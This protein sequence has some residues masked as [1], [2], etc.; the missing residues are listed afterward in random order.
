MSQ[1]GWLRCFV[2]ASHFEQLDTGLQTRINHQKQLCKN[3]LILSKSHFSPSLFIPIW[4][5]FFSRHAWH[6]FLCA[7]KHFSS[8]HPLSKVNKMQ[9]VGISSALKCLRQLV[10]L[11]LYSVF[12]IFC[13]FL[14]ICAKL[15]TLSI[16]HWPLPAWHLQQRNF[17]REICSENFCYKL[18]QRIFVIKLFR[19]T[20]SEK[21]F[22]I[23]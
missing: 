10:L 2:A 20:C 18:V 11:W 22:I 12:T 23:N 19:E 3:H 15:S 7:C 1:V 17:F 13:F 14:K 9:L 16:T 21:L 8:K 4:R 6:W 5:H